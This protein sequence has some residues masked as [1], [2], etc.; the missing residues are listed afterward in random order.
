V[1]SSTVT[2][3]TNEWNYI[4]S[5]GVGHF[6][7]N[8][9][10]F[11]LT[12]TDGG[13]SLVEYNIPLAQ[14]ITTTDGYTLHFRPETENAS[15]TGGSAFRTVGFLTDAGQGSDFYSIRGELPIECPVT[16]IIQ[17]W[18]VAKIN[19]SDADYGSA[20]TLAVTLEDQF[21]N[22]MSFTGVTVGAAS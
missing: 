18:S 7:T 6:V 5:M 11:T 15:G 9:Q 14:S 12:V 16:G 17:R 19:P 4:D 3:D 8:A 1:A 21:G 20:G 10:T 13:A 2:I 22:V